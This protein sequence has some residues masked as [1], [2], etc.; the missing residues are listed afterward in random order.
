MAVQ[1]AWQSKYRYVKI[2]SLLLIVLQTSVIKATSS[3]F[4]N[5]DNLTP[6]IE[7]VFSKVPEKKKCVKIRK[8]STQQTGEQNENRS[9]ATYDYVDPAL[10]KIL[11]TLKKSIETND[12]YAIQKLFHPRLAV[13]TGALKQIYIKIET[14]IGK[15]VEANIERV[16]ALYTKDGSS[17]DIECENDELFISPQYGYDFQY[18]V[19]VS[20]L[21]AKELGKIFLSLVP[22]NN[23]LY[24]GA[25]HFQIWTHMKKDYIGWIKDADIDYKEKN[26]ISAFIKYDLA[27]KLIFGKSFYRLKSESEIDK[28]IDENLNRKV[29]EQLLVD[30]LPS[31]TLIHA[32][33]IL[34][35]KGA[36]LMLRFSLDKE[37]S[38]YDIKEHCKKVF[39]TLDKQ[40]WFKK[41]HGVRCGYNLPQES[42]HLKDG[43]LGSIFIDK[44]DAYSKPK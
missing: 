37:L 11:S 2:F 8:K 6:I 30:S 33:S 35:S 7:K 32:T 12:H 9:K 28:F 18:G 14:N 25:F 23:H 15:K 42:N 29:W 34:A 19:W 44:T 39:R 21:G 13:S 4:S 24:I 5:Q 27:K 16:W 36:G 38:S 31:D 17:E 22:T 1:A 40:Q 26:L 41:L 3:K 10:E 20:I 43:V